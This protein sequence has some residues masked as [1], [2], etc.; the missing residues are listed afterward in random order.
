MTE[1]QAP[2][3]IEALVR[4]IDVLIRA[5]TCRRGYPTRTVERA[6]ISP[7][8]PTHLIGNTVF[9]GLANVARDLPPYEER[10]VMPFLFGPELPL[11]QSGLAASNPCD[12]DIA[13]AHQGD[14]DSD[15]DDDSGEHEYGRALGHRIHH[16]SAHIENGGSR[17]V[18]RPGPSLLARSLSPHASA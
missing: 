11:D 8:V 1:I 16:E 13:A 14:R 17:P 18:V 7:A 10:V 6:G 9:L 4:E 15:V 12:D 5:H 3:D 2:S